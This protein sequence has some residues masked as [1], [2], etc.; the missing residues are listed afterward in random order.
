MGAFVVIALFANLVISNAAKQVSNNYTRNLMGGA[1]RMVERD[2]TRYPPIAWQTRLEE[3]QADFDYPIRLQR[4]DYVTLASSRYE[5]LDD[6]NILIEGEGDIIYR[7]IGDS[8]MVL[9]LGPIRTEPKLSLRLGEIPLELR[10][11][12]LLWTLIGLGFAIALWF[13]VRPFW[14]DMESLRQ[15]ALIFAEGHLETRVGHASNRFVRPLAET[16]DHMA[17]RIQQLISTQRTLSGAISHELRTPISRLRF[18]LELVEK[19]QDEAYRTRLY[20]DMARDIA[21]LDHLIETSLTYARMERE[22]PVLILKAVWIENWLRDEIDK[23]EVLA[24]QVKIHLKL[25]DWCAGNP[26]MLDPKLMPQALGNL[27]GNAFKY[28]RTQVTV[29]AEKADAPE[30]MIEIHID[31]DGPG[32]PE[33]DRNRALA[34]FSRLAREEDSHQS[35]HG[36][37]LAIAQRIAELH[38]G[39]L[40]IDDSPH[41]GARLTLRWPQSGAAPSAL[42]GY[43]TETGR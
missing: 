39:E 6:G 18:A 15:T 27:L 37:G 32:I 2:L 4:R 35:G 12:V 23:R 5:L 21:E 36:L 24:S 26:V 38:R 7:S 43:G 30:E 11:R 31:D 25:S 42:H 8:G 28:A 40:L 33:A 3:L 10:I 16:M 1:V 19:T 20:A 41:G 29:S 34:A 14:R 9:L 13:W 17:E 22:K